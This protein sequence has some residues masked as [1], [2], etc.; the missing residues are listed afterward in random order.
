MTTELA[1]R[2]TLS[3]NIE[4]VLLAGD[5]AKLTPDERLNYYNAVCSSL[6]LNPLTQPFQYIVLNGKLQLYAKKDCTEQLR[7]IHGVSI[8][9]VDPKQIGDLVVVVADAADRD[10]RTD[11]STGAVAIVYPMRIK[12][13]EGKWKD[14]PKGGKQFDGEDL[15]NAMM[16]AETKAKRRVTLSICGLGMLDETEV[17]TLRE[18][19][20][21]QEPAGNKWVQQQPQSLPPQPQT[22]VDTLPSEP[23]IRPRSQKG[24]QPPSQPAPTPPAAPQ[25]QQQ[26][27]QG[28]VVGAEPGITQPQAKRFFAIM[29]SV[30]LSEEETK[31]R[32]AAIGWHGH[33]D[34]IPKRLYEK[35]IDAID[36]EFRFHTNQK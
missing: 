20:V 22:T 34:G 33:R 4:Q 1:T 29:R 36:N 5:L 17:D 27:V 13:F 26:A 15:A 7:K 23:D 14:H 32:L 12:D 25:P 6:G 28:E 18:Q 31:K 8:A 19:G 11:S 16:K 30:G 2:G 24:T 9:K 10:G 21:A 35:A 3:A